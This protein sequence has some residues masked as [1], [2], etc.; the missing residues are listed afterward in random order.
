MWWTKL[1]P[2]TRRNSF[3]FVCVFTALS[4]HPAA[5]EL[6]VK[7]VRLVLSPQADKPVARGLMQTKPGSPYSADRLAG[8]LRRLRMVGCVPATLELNFGADG[9]AISL[10]ASHTEDL[11][12]PY[13][14]RIK[15]TGGVTAINDACRQALSQQVSTLFRKRILNYRAVLRDK[16]TI[17]QEYAARGYLDARVRRIAVKASQNAR[18]ATVRFEVGPGVLFTLGKVSIRHNRQIKADELIKALGLGAKTTWTKNVRARIV[19]RATR[20]CR[21]RGYL[22]ASVEA[23]AEKHPRGTVDLRLEL[24]EG[25]QYVLRNAIVRGAGNYKHQVAELITLRKD[26]PVKQPEVDALRHAIEDIGVFTNIEILFVPLRGKPPGHCDMVIRLTPVD[27]GR[28]IG[29][30]A[31]RY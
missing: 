9:A 11:S 1:K 6:P 24:T 16:R 14:Q 3:F 17:E 13:V 7:S 2:R 21:E 26:Q 28:A 30:A 10:S 31:K 23:V 15:F 19:D 12:R 29:E 5:A 25:N 27:L 20:F 18:S 4:A 22:D 8:D